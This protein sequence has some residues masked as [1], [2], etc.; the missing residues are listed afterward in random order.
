MNRPLFEPRKDYCATLS[1]GT[2]SDYMLSHV[3]SLDAYDF[4]TAVLLCK[5]CAKMRNLTINVSVRL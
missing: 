2:Y 1:D 4:N 3:T 5:A